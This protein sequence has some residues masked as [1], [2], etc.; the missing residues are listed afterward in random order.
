MPSVSTKNFPRFGSEIDLR[1]DA[2]CSGDALRQ[3]KVTQHSF[4]QPGDMPGT[5]V[6]A[7]WQ[8]YLQGNSRLSYGGS[9]TAFFRVSHFLA[10]TKAN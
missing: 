1:S 6:Y 2:V 10:K 9:R 5:A 8:A 3:Q 7:T 4:L